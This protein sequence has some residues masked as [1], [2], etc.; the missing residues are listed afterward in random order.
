MAEI[1]IYTKHELKIL[2]FGCFSIIS[3]RLAR[4]SIN[5]NRQGVITSF[6]ARFNYAGNGE[7]RCK[8]SR[9]FLTTDRALKR[10]AVSAANFKC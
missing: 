3:T 1:N 8:R 5:K 6:A 4:G 2:L 9:T 7:R 10:A